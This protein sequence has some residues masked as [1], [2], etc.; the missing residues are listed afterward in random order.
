MESKPKPITR[1]PTPL[2]PSLETISKV[3]SS[4]ES[5][6]K[7][8]VPSIVAKTQQQEEDTLDHEH[9]EKQPLTT[10]EFGDEI[11]EV[12]DLIAREMYDDVH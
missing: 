7:P 5:G 10:V 3:T 11:P 9:N 1:G 2:K 6:S 4:A 8:V 12:E